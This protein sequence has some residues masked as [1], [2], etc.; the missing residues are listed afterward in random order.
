MRNENNLEQARPIKP[1]NPPSQSDLDDWQ[2]NFGTVAS[3]ITPAST[4][5]P[6]PA[7][8]TMLMLGMAPCYP[9]VGQLCQNSNLTFFRKYQKRNHFGFPASNLVTDRY[10]KPD[11]DA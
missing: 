10:H 11:T 1:P 5:V 9:C 4:A 7:T 6:E 8:G 3:S 2:E